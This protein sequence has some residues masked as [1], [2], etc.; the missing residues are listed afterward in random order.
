MLYLTRPGAS[1]P[2][3]SAPR[4]SSLPLL[5]P[6]HTSHL[7]ASGMTLVQKGKDACC[8]LPL[9]HPDSSLHYPVCEDLQLITKLQSEIHMTEH[10]YFGA[11]LELFS[12]RD[13]STPISQ[14]CAEIK[15]FL[16]SSPNT[17]SH[18]TL[19]S[20]LKYLSILIKE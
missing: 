20:I 9:S 16:A 11:G 12:S 7:V 19:E 17:A 1:I 2:E 5:L 8:P 15:H 13:T 14:A 10:Y 6:P 4:D 3:A 18:S